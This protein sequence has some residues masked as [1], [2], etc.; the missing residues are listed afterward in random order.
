MQNPS[1][2]T[3]CAVRTSAIP[4]FLGLALAASAGSWDSF[5]ALPERA[6]VVGELAGE[7]HLRGDLAASAAVLALR[8]RLG[9]V[10]LVDGVP[11]LRHGRGR[12]RRGDGEQEEEV[13]DDGLLRRREAAV[14][15][16]RHGDV[17]PQHGAV[18]VREL[19]A[20]RWLVQLH[21]PPGSRGGMCRAQQQY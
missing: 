21:E 1:T 2:D 3:S 14:P 18:V 6:L 13:G 17:A 19:L 7:P 5:E 16:D 15:D 9:Q 11:P 12:R 4:P 10:Q 8:R 20:G